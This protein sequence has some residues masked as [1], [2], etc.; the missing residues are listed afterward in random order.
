MTVVGD[1]RIRS[2]RLL[3]AFA[4]TSYMSICHPAAV[5]GSLSSVLRTAI[6]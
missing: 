2:N 3:H 5:S 6:W 1:E 4:F